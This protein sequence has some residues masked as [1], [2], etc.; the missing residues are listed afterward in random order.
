V[1]STVLIKYWFYILLYS[2]KELL[3]VPL[4]FP[5]IISQK[6]FVLLCWHGYTISFL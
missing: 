4:Y 2:T 5:L 3:L 1:V 6:Y